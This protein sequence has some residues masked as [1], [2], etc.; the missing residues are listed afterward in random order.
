MKSLLF[1]SLFWAISCAFP[2]QHKKQFKVTLEKSISEPSFG[3]RPVSYLVKQDQRAYNHGSGYY[4][5]ISI[6]TP[7][8]PFKVVFDTGSA[9]LWVISSDCRNAVCRSQHTAFNAAKSFTFEDENQN[10]QIDY[11]T[12][13]VY[14]QQGRESVRIGNSQDLLIEG[15]SFINILSLSRDFVGAPFQGIF[16]LGL[17]RIASTDQDPPIISMVDQGILDEPL[18]AIYS[19]HNA[20]EIDFG[21]IDPYR[22]H[23]DLSFVNVIDD[24]YWM[25]Q[26]K[27]AQFNDLYYPKRRAIIDSGS[28]L[29][30]MPKRDAEMYHQ[31]I[32]GAMKNGDGTWSFPCKNVPFLQPLVLNTEQGPLILPARALFLTPIH[33]TSRM[34]L[35]GVS[36]QNVQSWILGDVFLKHFYT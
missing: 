9:D 16:G 19:Q 26:L 24:G 14:G 28:T 31:G 21:G 3:T 13:S 23:G 5:E 12:G 34:C 36:G 22:F 30:I 32:M 27:S 35:S 10:T 2:T 25:I 8:Q 15:Q 33:S 7:P 11:G 17:P 29:I 6:G 4:G 20:G 1:F 18:F